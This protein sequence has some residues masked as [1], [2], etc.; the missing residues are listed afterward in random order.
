MPP[1]GREKGLSGRARRRDF[2]KSAN[3][4]ANTGKRFWPMLAR[5]FSTL[6]GGKVQTC[7]QE[8]ANTGV[9]STPFRAFMPLEKRPFFRL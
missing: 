5:V 4:F 6:E 7:L 8:S 2:P 9:E 3:I 1:Q